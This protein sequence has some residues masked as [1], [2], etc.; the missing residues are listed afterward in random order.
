[1]LAADALASDYYYSYYDGLGL[2]T[3]PRVFPAADFPGLSSAAGTIFIIAASAG[4]V[5]T[6]DPVTP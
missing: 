1:M 4:V 2:R 6:A 5:S 3:L